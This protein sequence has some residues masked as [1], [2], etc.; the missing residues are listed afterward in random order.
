MGTDNHQRKEIAMR[1]GSAAAV[2]ALLLATAAPL[3]SACSDPVPHR[4]V[5]GVSGM[6]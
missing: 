1:F 3:F 2:T 4:Y 5:V 6:H